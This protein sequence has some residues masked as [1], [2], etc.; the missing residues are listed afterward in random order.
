MLLSSRNNELGR[1]SR[2]VQVRTGRKDEPNDGQ[3]QQAMRETLQATESGY[4][5]N[6]VSFS[7]QRLMGI[8]SLVE[9]K[10]GDVC[11][12][13]IVECVVTDVELK[14]IKKSLCPHQN[15]KRIGMKL[16]ERVSKVAWFMADLRGVLGV[17]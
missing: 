3:D 11:L 1:N 14:V 17:C 16:R 5:G 10:K 6:S 8:G 9:D 15:W 12:V 13:V 4:R 2:D 7:V